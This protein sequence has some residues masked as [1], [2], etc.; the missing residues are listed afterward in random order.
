MEI[1][2]SHNN[3]TAAAVVAASDGDDVYGG[4]AVPAASFYDGPM[5]YGG[6]ATA[7]RPLSVMEGDPLG[8]ADV[9]EEFE[10]LIRQSEGFTVKYNDDNDREDDILRSQ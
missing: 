1:V 10:A 7:G 6:A 4:P 5:V 3:S 8:Y 9:D 2:Q